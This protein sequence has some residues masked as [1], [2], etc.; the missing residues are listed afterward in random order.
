MQ[1]TVLQHL[2]H[3]TS[4]TALTELCKGVEALAAVALAAKLCQS[5]DSFVPSHC[6]L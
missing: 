6:D 4:A 5:K 3:Y 1:S 2:N